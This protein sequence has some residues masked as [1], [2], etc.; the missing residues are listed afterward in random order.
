MSDDVFE[1]TKPSALSW[2]QGAFALA[3]LGAGATAASIYC[4][5]I[6]AAALSATLFGA[7]GFVALFITALI[8]FSGRQ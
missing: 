1:R 2:Y 3:G 7:A 4:D 8:V 6:W 5:N